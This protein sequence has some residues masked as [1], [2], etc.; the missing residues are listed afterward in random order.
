MADHDD[1]V[2]VDSEEVPDFSYEPRQVTPSLSLKGGD[3][4]PGG[5]FS[6]AGNSGETSSGQENSV[7]ELIIAVFVVQFDTRRGKLIS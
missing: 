4:N 5:N 3:V 2:L 7:P 6:L 1:A